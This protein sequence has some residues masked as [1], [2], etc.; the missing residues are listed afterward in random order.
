MGGN[1]W[2]RIHRCQFIPLVIA[3]KPRQVHLDKLDMG[4]C[5]R[6]HSA[7]LG[8]NFI[9]KNTTCLD[10]THYWLAHV[11]GCETTTPRPINYAVYILH[12]QSRKLQSADNGCMLGGGGLVSV[13][14]TSGVETSELISLPRRFMSS[15][16]VARSA[17]LS[18]TISPRGTAAKRKGSTLLPSLFS[19]GV[20]SC[21]DE[22]F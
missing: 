6:Y 1:I 7:K 9:R 10:F 20:N 15:L 3:Y 19:S 16:T 12:S 5:F 4:K 22:L 18:T 8:R 21:H 17:L 11:H 2:I 13:S 14:D